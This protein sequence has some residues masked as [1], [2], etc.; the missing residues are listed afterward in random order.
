[1]STPSVQA[2]ILAGGL[3]TR[4]KS[5]V[6]KVLHDLLGHPMLWYVVDALKDID[7]HP[8]VVTPAADEPFRA[9]FGNRMAAVMPSSAALTTFLPSTSLYATGTIPFRPR[10]TIAS[11][12]TRV[13]LDTQ[14]R[15]SLRRILM[16]LA[17][18]DASCA[19]WTGS[20]RALSRHETR[21]RNNFVFAR[22]TPASTCSVRGSF[23]SG[24]R[25]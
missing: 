10:R 2:L 8:V 14:R 11:F 12:L 17:N 25:R 15:Q 22:S 18:W 6:P 23:A 13:L 21:A 3:G 9:A 24:W 20:L 5:A 1:M 19:P 16:T 4:M 7:V